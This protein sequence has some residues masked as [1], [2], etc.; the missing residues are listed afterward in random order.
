[1]DELITIHFA[2]ELIEEVRNRQPAATSTAVG[3]LAN[4]VPG[5]TL[6]GGVKDFLALGNA[7]MSWFSIVGHR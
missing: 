3:L 7:Y 2:K 6:I 1:V 4:F 5:G